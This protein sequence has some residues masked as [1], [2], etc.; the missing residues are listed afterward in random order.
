MESVL[1]LSIGVHALNNTGNPERLIPSLLVFGSLREMTL[2]KER[3]LQLGSQQ[4]SRWKE[5]SQFRDKN[6]TKPTKKTKSKV[7]ALRQVQM[8]LFIEKIRKFGISNSNI[9]ARTIIK[10]H[11]L[12][13]E[14]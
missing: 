3:D 13:Q 4:G 6:G 5:F 2:G 7:L 11:M 1:P 12:K 10:Q 8:F 9:F 14:S